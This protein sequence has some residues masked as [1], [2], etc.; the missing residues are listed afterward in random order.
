M[1]RRT[2]KFKN[3]FCDEPQADDTFPEIPL[4]YTRMDSNCAA[5]SSKY[6]AFALDGGGGPFTYRRLTEFG[7][8][9]KTMPNINTHKGKLQCLEFSPFNPSIIVTGSEDNTIAINNLGEFGELTET[10]KVADQ[11]LSG[12]F[13]HTKKV[14]H[15]SWCHQSESVLASGGFDQCVKIWDAETADCMR[16]VETSDKLGDVKFNYEG[17]LVAICTKDGQNTIMDPRAPE[18]AFTFTS[19]NS[20]KSSKC[21]FIPEFNWFGQIGFG[22]QSKRILKLWDL[23]DTSTPIHKWDIDQ[24]GSAL[25]PTF[26]ETTNML[27]IT[28]K[29]DGSVRWLEIANGTK[30]LHHLGIYRNSVPQRGG[31]FVPKKGLQ[32]MKC[33]LMRFMKITQKSVI[34][35]AFMVPRKATNFQDDIFVPAFDGISHITAEDWN[36]GGNVPIVKSSMNPQDWAEQ[37]EVVVTKAKK[38]SYKELQQ[39]NE[40]LRTRIAE[41]EEQVRTLTPAETPAETS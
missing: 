39:E 2:S 18:S 12:E 4:P 9:N 33:E 19:F 40:E 14:T 25:I 11:Y 34:P 26:D 41:L 23:A 20:K 22:S 29:G 6:F 3:V 31:C 35:L 5:A 30:K 1:S 38:K 17:N 28:G 36:N 37:A 16:T 27:W 32:I 15:L 7:R 21:W 8:I 13:G 10:K 24:N